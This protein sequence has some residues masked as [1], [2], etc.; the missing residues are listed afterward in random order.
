MQNREMLSA[1][2]VAGYKRKVELH[3]QFEEVRYFV[4][5]ALDGGR[6]ERCIEVLHVD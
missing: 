5:R 1:C 3:G 6:R 4:W 2:V